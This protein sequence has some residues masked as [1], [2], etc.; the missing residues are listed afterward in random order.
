ML[1]SKLVC[2]Q[3]AKAQLNSLIM[4]AMHVIAAGIGFPRHMHKEEG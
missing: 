1:E 3:E 2:Q 4:V